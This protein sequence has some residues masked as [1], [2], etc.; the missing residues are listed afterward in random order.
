[1]HL[2]ELV[3]TK[4]EGKRECLL[5]HGLKSTAVGIFNAP[6][7]TQRCPPHSMAPSYFTREVKVILG[8]LVRPHD[9]AWKEADKPELVCYWVKQ[10]PPGVETFFAGKRHV[11]LKS[12]ARTRRART[13]APR[14][15]I[16]RN[17][18][19]RAT[20]GAD[21]GMNGFLKIRGF[22]FA[23]PDCKIVIEYAYADSQNQES[24]LSAGEANCEHFE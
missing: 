8:S 2:H 21:S 20:T 17:T 18:P 23:T 9:L 5:L 6:R 10:G 24:K 12:R 4:L 16:S 22:R 19:S 1:M 3:R 13:E 7:I 14:S 15:A 11:V